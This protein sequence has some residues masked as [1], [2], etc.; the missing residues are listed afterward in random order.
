[1]DVPNK[2]D[3][4][5]VQKITVMKKGMLLAL[6]VL[7]AIT[8]AQGN[9]YIIKGKVGTLNAPTKVYLSHRVAGKNVL[10]ST[11]IKDG[12]FQFKGIVTGP[13][14]ALIAIDHQGVG[15]TA[16]GS[17]FD[18]L[19]VYLD[20]GTITVS[21]K[22]SVK[23]G[24]ITGSAINAENEKYKNFIAGPDQVINNI[25]KEYEAASEEKKKDETYVNAL[26][27]KYDEAL[28]QKAQLQQKFVSQYPASYFSLQA[29][30]DMVNDG[31]E[32]TKVETLFKGLSTGIRTSAEGKEF[33]TVLNKTH[34]TA[35]GAIAPDFTQND[36]NDKPV[37]LSELRG[38]YVLLDFWASWCGP[39]RKENPNVV[40]AYNTY[41]DKNFTV[42]GVSLDE[43]K[44][45]DW[46]KAIKKDGLTWT[47]VSDLKGWSNEV[48]QL[49]GIRSIPQN[50]LLDPTGKIVG[51]NL[52]GE[53]LE[54]KLAEVLNN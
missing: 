5:Q 35:I 1:V 8:W 11:S 46:L 47:H 51:K 31:T 6:L 37:K 18:G 7:P 53:D 3:K 32:L 12:A 9:E 17:N 4:L 13:S 29:L 54:K 21:A 34:A 39:C 45:D 42:L 43:D 16:M 52:R 15:A 27:A 23:Y 38:K 36:V 22:D 14:K 10:D 25:N 33:E 26:K 2:L 20:K 28:T 44:K 24:K 50:F 41:K 49:Y 40:K 30:K 48:A 19:S